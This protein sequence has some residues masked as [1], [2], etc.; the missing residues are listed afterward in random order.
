MMM[1][2]CLTFNLLCVTAH[3]LVYGRHQVNN[4]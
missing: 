1:I 3:P 2:P 4:V